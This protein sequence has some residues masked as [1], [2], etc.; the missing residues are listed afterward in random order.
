[1]S[2]GFEETPKV[3]WRVFEWAYANDIDVTLMKEYSYG[4][5]AY[6]VLRFRRNGKT[7]QM[8]L[9]PA[10]DITGQLDFAWQSIALELCV[11]PLV[12]S[13]LEASH[14]PQD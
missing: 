6:P 3:M 7:T 2:L 13:D 1:M 8:A 10:T 11:E 4:R 5:E 12:L 9:F 14:D